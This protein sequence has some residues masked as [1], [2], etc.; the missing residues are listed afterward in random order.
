[1]TR[2]KKPEQLSEAV[3]ATLSQ[4]Y[5]FAPE[6]AAGASEKEAVRDEAATLAAAFA[7][8]RRA[9]DGVDAPFVF[10][11]QAAGQ[12]GPL[13]MGRAWRFAGALLAAAAAVAL[14][15]LLPP[16][17]RDAAPQIQDLGHSGPDSV[18]HVVAPSPGGLLSVWP[19][20]VLNVHTPRLAIAPGVRPAGD[21]LEGDF[22]TRSRRVGVSTT[23]F[24]RLKTARLSPT[25]AVD[26]VSSTVP[27]SASMISKPRRKSHDDDAIDGVERGKANDGVERGG[28]SDRQLIGPE[29]LG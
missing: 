29:R 20:S 15:V 18:T 7:E 24:V 4:S 27:M 1:M 17:F 23:S 13:V 19:P 6:L 11:P 25:I 9:Y 21:G 14:V 26:G 5:A 28:S 12:S 8:L 22:A 3:V 16:A 10:D 2:G